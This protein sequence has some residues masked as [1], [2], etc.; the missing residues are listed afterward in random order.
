MYIVEPNPPEVPLYTLLTSSRPVRTSPDNPDV[1][2]WIS[3][4]EL[5]CNSCTYTLRT[6]DP[7]DPD[8]N[9]GSVIVQGDPGAVRSSREY[10]P[11]GIDVIDSF[12]TFGFGA[13]D[14]N[15][16][17]QEI[18]EVA[19]IKAVERE[20]WTGAAIPDNPHLA[21]PSATNITPAAGAVKLKVGVALL[22]Q[23]FA[24]C[25]AGST[26]VIHMTRYAGS[27]FGTSGGD[28]EGVP[29]RT[30]FGNIVVPGI[31]YTGTGPTGAAPAAGRTWL[32]GTGP[33]TVRLSDPVVVPESPS[34]GGVNTM[35]NTRTYRAQRFA[36]VTL[37][38]CCHYAVEV[39]LAA[40]A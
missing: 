21:Q 9:S 16:Q 37:D 13:L 17:G 24:D 19:T 27:L 15:E 8:P 10:T 36:A 5:G 3:G 25:A 20:F 14:V 32:Y 33:I 11:F 29:T 39:D 6:F 28:E 38:G 18:I 23:A 4:M 35:N 30:G 12:S 34:I 26:G 22:E 31:G 40:S 7:C 2:R 1:D